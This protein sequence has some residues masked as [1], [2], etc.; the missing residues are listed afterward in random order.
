MR[1]LSVSLPIILAVIIAITACAQFA[2]YPV[3][4][5][6]IAAEKYESFSG[7]LT[8][9]VDETLTVQFPQLLKWLNEITNL[10]EKSNR[11]LYL[12]CEQ[13]PAGR[14]LSST[15]GAQPADILLCAAGH[16]PSAQWNPPGELSL[17]PCFTVCEGAA[18]PV[19]AGGYVLG[20]RG[21]PPDDLSL[22]PDHSVGCCEEFPT[23]LVALCEQFSPISTEIP[24]L[25]APDIG[26]PARQTPVPTAAPVT[27][28]TLG[29]RNLRIAG[30]EELYAAFLSGEI[31]AMPLNQEQIAKISRAQE[32]GKHA[33][34]RF[35]NAAA[36]TD[37]V[38]YAA[39]PQ[40]GRADGTK[41]STAAAEFLSFMLSDSAQRRLEKH[42]MFPAAPTESLYSGASGFQQLESMLRRSECVVQG[43][44]EAD[45]RP[46]TA[47]FFS[48][49]ISAREWMRRLRNSR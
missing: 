3:P 17:L 21:T 28:T 41:R 26:L 49:E 39:L 7:V 30:A 31:R 37:L 45:L 6:G 14:L 20:F 32:D 46:D 38:V 48:G 23:V 25:P 27:G 8:I 47:D 12:R 5:E 13:Y 40:S 24:T 44:A 11:G 43:A 16:L 2:R 19:A 22:L 4:P 29:A 42:R 33:D 36:F 9:A 15:Q 35:L 34:I 1:F 18:V 10:F